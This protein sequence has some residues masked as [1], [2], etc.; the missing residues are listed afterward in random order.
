MKYKSYSSSSQAKDPENNIPTFHDYCVTGADHKNKTNHC[1]STFHLWRLVLKKKNDELIEMWED[2]DWVSPEKILD[3][4]INSVD[5]LYS[6]KENFASIE[7]G[8][9]IELEFRIAHNAS[10][11]DLSKMPGK[12]PK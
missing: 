4:L 8:E 9:K 7:T 11:F 2:M 6:G 10:S 3:I 5:N 12:P 1:F